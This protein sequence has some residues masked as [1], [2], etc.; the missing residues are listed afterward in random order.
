MFF[1][2]FCQFF[3][4]IICG[5]LCFLFS[6]DLR[7]G[8]L[9]GECQFLTL[10]L[11]PLVEDGVQLDNKELIVILL[12]GLSFSFLGV[13]ICLFFEPLGV[14]NDLV[15]DQYVFKVDLILLLVILIVS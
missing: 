15:A 8:L 12:V 11:S 6:L 14:L 10:L 4:V 5:L 9:L 13:K 7:I 1:F 3:E 2:F